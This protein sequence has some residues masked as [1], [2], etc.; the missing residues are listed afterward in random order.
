MPIE[1][2]KRVFEVCCDFL[3]VD[4]KILQQALEHHL[5]EVAG[6]IY[7]LLVCVQKNIA[8]SKTLS[9]Y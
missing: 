9:E 7:N 6:R 3:H 8:I 4:N 5:D 1:L 2:T